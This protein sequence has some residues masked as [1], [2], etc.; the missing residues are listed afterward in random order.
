MDISIYFQPIDPEL[1]YYIDD[2][3][4]DKIGNNIIKY[5]EDGR[6]PDI[7]ECKIVIIGVKEDRNA[8]NN[9]GCD[10]A[11]DIVRNYFYNLYPG[12][13]NFKIA[14]I[15]NIITGHTAE[16]TYYALTH[17][18]SEL[19][20]LN[21]TVIIIG[22][23]QDLTHSIYN[24][25]H[26]LGQVINIAAVDY[27]FDIGTIEM[28]FNSRS[29]LTKI[30][31]EQPNYL[32]NYTNIGYQTFFVDQESIELMK[33]LF[34]DTYR[35]GLI[36]ADIEEVEPIVR[37][38]D[39]MSFD[40]SAIRH[41]DS[42]GN[43]NAS[44]NGFFA[45]EACQITR[46]AGLSDKMSCIGFFENNPKVDKNNSTSHIVAQMM[47]YF[48]EGYSNRLNELNIRH[49]SGYLKYTVSLKN[50]EYEIVFYKSQRSERWWMEVPFP[51]AD[52]KKV[53]RRMLVPCSY[54][55]YLTA[56][57]DEMPDRWWQTHNKYL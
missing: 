24:A 34:F 49:K 12:K 38:C 44:P 50:D 15:G 57:K 22:G 20:K 30:I 46:F 3:H 25:Y 54:N 47:W 5:E 37:N 13:F 36:K 11:P 23:S 42:P 2:V 51:I 55:D 10:L 27:A 43:K 19:I 21:K 16:D 40:V 45:D 35:L 4:K 8:V 6:F 26:K 39:V 14:D 18:V 31:T 32:F 56:M 9:S 17:S 29:Y 48:I 53:E 1:I 41:S 33:N 28:D 52:P 7:E